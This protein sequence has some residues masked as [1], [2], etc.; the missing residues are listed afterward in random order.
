VA[1]RDRDLDPARL[2]GQL[3][4]LRPR[5]DADDRGLANARPRDLLYL[6]ALIV[7][8]LV[9]RAA[10]LYLLLPLFFLRRPERRIG[11][12]VRLVILWGG[13]RGAVTLALVLAL[14]EAGRIPDEVRQVALVLAVGFVL[15]TLLV[16]GTTL[17][18]LLRLVGLDQL[19][20]IERGLR[21]RAAVVAEGQILK[22]LSEIAITYGIDL[23][24]AEEAL[25]LFDRRNKRDPTARRPA[26]TWRAGSS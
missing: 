14:T 17:R 12:R 2:L 25:T 4:R 10:C 19:D 8:A 23:E 7:G 11:N 5:L 20:P 1:E 24:R 21:E 9:A 22:R 18:P 15:F 6:A 16:Q 26:A 3:A 13:L